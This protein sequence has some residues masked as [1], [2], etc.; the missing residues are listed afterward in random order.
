M[1]GLDKIF[2]QS[3]AENP[4][5]GKMM[6]SL[7]MHPQKN[8]C[9]CEAEGRGNLPVKCRKSNILGGCNQVYKILHPF[10]VL[11]FVRLHQ[12]IAT[13]LRASQ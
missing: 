1:R 6:V 10:K 12:E 8:A 9:H 7:R 3:C 11:F 4:L 13:A 2:A 5:V